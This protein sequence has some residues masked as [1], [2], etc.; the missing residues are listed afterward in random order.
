MI[1]KHYKLGIG[2]AVRDEVGNF[3]ATTRKIESCAPDLAIAKAKRAL[4][5]ADFGMQL[6]MR[7]VELEGDSMKVVMTI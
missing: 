2:I 5:A 1:K 4:I 6:G 7:K 3:F